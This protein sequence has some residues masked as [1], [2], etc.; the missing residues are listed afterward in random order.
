MSKKDLLN[1]AVL[2]PEVDEQI[3]IAGIL[4]KADNE[5]NLAKQKLAT[6]KE[7]KKGLMQHLLTGKKR[8][9]V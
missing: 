7:Q 9:K 5:I 2:I 8:V 3:A 1:I 6:L 4:S